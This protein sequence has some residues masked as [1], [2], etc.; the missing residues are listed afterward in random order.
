[1]IFKNTYTIA[2]VVSGSVFLASTMTSMAG[3]G[4]GS[5]LGEC[6]NNW[7]SWCNEHTAGYPNNCYGESLNRCDK[8]H[9]AMSTLPGYKVNSMKST[10]LRK[11]KRANTTLV[12]PTVQP[13]RR[14]N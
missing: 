7:I 10:A 14:A 12:A 5:N 2:L 6:Y 4:N 13:V 9:K 3:P 8:I 11:A 1:M